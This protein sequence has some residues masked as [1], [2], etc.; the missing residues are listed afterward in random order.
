MR[1]IA[2]VEAVQAAEKFVAAE[3]VGRKRIDHVLDLEGDDVAAGEGWP[4]EH[5]AEQ[6][7]RQQVLDQHLLDRGLCQVRVDRLAAFVQKFGERGGEGVVAFPLL[8]DQ[9]GQA[10]ADVRDPVLELG[11]GLLPR[12][13]LLRPVAEE[14]LQRLDQLP[15][16][17]QI[18]VQRQPPVLPQHRPPRRLKQDI[19]ARVS[20][21]K[22]ALHLRRQ[23][24]V[25]VLRLPAPVR[26]P[27]IVHQRPVHHNPPAPPR[28]HPKLRHQRPPTLPRA[29]PQQ[30]LKRR[31]HRRLMR[32][33]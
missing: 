25:N 11:D 28:T 6:P 1:S 10:L 18:R 19:V 29:M 22:L 12:R 33:V 26:Q 30:R 13:I 21:R 20:R 27:E 16:V 4:V 5:R 15:R 32:D 9:L 7:L 8:L 24:V 3:G 2:T 23:I 31:P 14:H 17:R